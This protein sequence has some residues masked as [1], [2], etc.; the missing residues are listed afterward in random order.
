MEQ[1][2]PLSNTIGLSRPAF[3]SLGFCPRGLINNATNRPKIRETRKRNKENKEYLKNK[4]DSKDNAETE[5]RRSFI[6]T[7]VR[8]QR[9]RSHHKGA[10]GR[11][12]TGDQRYPVLCH[13]QLGQDI[14]I[15][16]KSPDVLQTPA[17]TADMR[18]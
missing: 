3:A 11:V 8:E 18:H 4:G 1:L 9:P 16:V 12:R 10:T 13:C 17:T 6:T 15:N 14:P 2:N 5:I 7:T